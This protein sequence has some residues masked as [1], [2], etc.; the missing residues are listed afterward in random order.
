VIKDEISYLFIVDLNV[1]DPNGDGLVE[2]VANLMVDLLNSP[3]NNASL[4]IVIGE[5]EHGEGFSSSRLAI[6]HDSAIVSG[7]DALD[8]GC[9][10]Q[11]VDIVLGSIV[12]DVV[13]LK[14]PVIQLIVYGSVV[15]LV[16]VH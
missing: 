7:D 14:L 16:S 10:R 15:H 5:A 6:A 2:L 4:L 3:G 13:K 8:N 9:G 11:I 12:E 1:T